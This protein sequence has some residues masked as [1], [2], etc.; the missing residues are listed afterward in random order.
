MFLPK[1]HRP[2]PL[3]PTPMR[4]RRG[5]RRLASQ[6][7]KHT[8]HPRRRRDPLPREKTHTFTPALDVWAIACTLF[9]LFGNH[10]VF[11]SLFGQHAEMRE[12][13][14][15]VTGVRDDEDCRVPL[16]T[17]LQQLVIG[18]SGPCV[19]DGE[20]LAAVVNIWMR[21]SRIVDPGEKT[22]ADMVL[23]MLPEAWKRGDG[24][25]LMGADRLRRERVFPMDTCLRTCHA[26][27]DAERR[28]R[29]HMDAHA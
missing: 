14:E 9:E 3:H 4:L 20:E 6:R 24:T 26:R 17:R 11:P 23:S 5:I 1:A 22:T 10:N 29:T 21:C 15:T 18:M 7:P 16:R 2:M 25:M 12:Q 28:R 13:I 19:L 8:D 27:S